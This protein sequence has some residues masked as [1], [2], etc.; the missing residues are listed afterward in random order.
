[1]DMIKQEYT[2]ANTSINKNRIP[3]LFHQVIFHSGTV[4]LDYGGGKYDT[5]TEYLALQGVTNLIYDPYNRTVEHNQAVTNRV[6][7]M[8]GADTVTC[9]NVLNVIKELEVRIDLLKN[10]QRLVKSDGY[11][12]ITVY[13]GNKSGIG[14]PT[15]A[16][17]QLNRRTSEYLEE[18]KMVFP[19]AY[20]KGKVIIAQK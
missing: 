17:Y 13:E 5:A 15:T 4:N 9:S 2:S 14:K 11:V 20:Q 6:I 12:Y 8:G 7:R 1:M 16:G 18:V 10:I 19:N 3:A